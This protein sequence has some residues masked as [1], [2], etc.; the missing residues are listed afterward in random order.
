MLIDGG[1]FVIVNISTTGLPADSR[2]PGYR[3]DPETEAAVRGATGS[4]A[5][6]RLQG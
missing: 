6:I 4:R 1:E 3:L 2:Q 5:A